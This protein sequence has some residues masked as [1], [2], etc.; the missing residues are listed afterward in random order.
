MVYEVRI[1]PSAEKGLNKIDKKYKSK[2]L[3]NLNQL[4]INP[5]IGKKLTGQYEGLFSL[6]VWPYRIIYK[7]YKKYLLVVVIKIAHRQG[8]YK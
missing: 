2:I 7:I 1:E 8:V 5:Y 6:R 4:S 3:L